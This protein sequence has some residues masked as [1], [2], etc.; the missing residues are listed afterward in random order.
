MEPWTKSWKTAGLWVRA[1]DNL[2]RDGRAVLLGQDN[3]QKAR[4]SGVWAARGYPHIPALWKAV[5]A[6]GD[7]ES[8]QHRVRW[9]VRVLRGPLGLAPL[10]CYTILE[11]AF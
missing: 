11:K 2:P 7:C 3:A 4:I 10:R 9:L 6:R 8:G 1:V 5:E